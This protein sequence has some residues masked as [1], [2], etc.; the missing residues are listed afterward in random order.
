MNITFALP[1]Y[2]SIALLSCL[3]SIFGL[4]AASAKKLD[5]ETRYSILSMGTTCLAAII[6]I[7]SISLPFL[8]NS[9]L[10]LLLCSAGSA[11]SVRELKD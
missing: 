4:Q 5:L 10:I 2:I 6:A 9:C 11:I 1:I 8:L 3:I 7:K